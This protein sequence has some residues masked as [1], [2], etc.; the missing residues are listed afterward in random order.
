MAHAVVASYRSSSV[1]LLPA[2]PG[3]GLIAGSAARAVLE[4]A[5]VRDCLTKALG[6]KNAVNLAKATFEGLVGM[7]THQQVSSARGVSLR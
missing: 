5:G 2:A 7:R 4:A 1:K 3:T 6:S